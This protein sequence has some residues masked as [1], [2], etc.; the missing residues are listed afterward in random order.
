M[1]TSIP[2]NCSSM[3]LKMSSSSVHIATDRTDEGLKDLINSA[4]KSVWPMRDIPSRRAFAC[5]TI[6]SSPSRDTSFQWA[7]RVSFFGRMTPSNKRCPRVRERFTAGNSSIN[8]PPISCQNW[9]I[10]GVSRLLMASLS[11]DKTKCCKAGTARRFKNL[12]PD[13]FSGRCPPYIARSQAPAWE[14]EE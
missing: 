3:G 11:Q 9:R 10:I 12:W 13:T 6:T 14:R 8:V 2:G 7:I 4:E 1:M 5:T